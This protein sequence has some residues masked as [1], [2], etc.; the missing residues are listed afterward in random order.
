MQR[1]FVSNAFSVIPAVPLRNENSSVQILVLKNRFTE[2][3][4]ED[5][6]GPGRELLDVAMG[7]TKGCRL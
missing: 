6:C 7:V 5:A 1:Y 2:Q 4:G 3:A